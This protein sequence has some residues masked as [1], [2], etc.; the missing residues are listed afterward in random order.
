MLGASFNK[1][2]AP[3]F[4]ELISQKRQIEIKNIIIRFTKLII[5]FSAV[6][7]VVFIAFSKS[8]LIYWLGDGFEDIYLLLSLVV[9]NQLLHQTTSLTFT[10]F[11][12]INKLKIPA[13]MTLITGV[14]NILLSIYLVKE[15]TLGIYRVVTGTFISIFIKT[16]LFN[17]IYASRLLKIS[18]FLIWKSALQGLYLPII[19]ALSLFFVLNFASIT[20]I[21][22]LLIYIVF[23][24]L[25]YLASVLYFSL[26]KN[27]RHFLLK[28]SKL[29]RL[30][31][32]L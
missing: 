32:L 9:S 27:D 13:F 11:N 14:L 6:P 23:T 15:T 16:I 25:L 4:I 22:N 29:D 21:F 12:M 19:F 18:P 28:I 2:L 5:L 30:K 20:S 17:V 8:I 24:L 3:V 7:F 26:S 10:Y 31:Q 1:I